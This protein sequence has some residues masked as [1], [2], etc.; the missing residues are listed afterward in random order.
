MYP[1][2]E[3]SVKVSKNVMLQCKKKEC[4]TQDNLNAKRKIEW[5]R[6]GVGVRWYSVRVSPS[7]L[8]LSL[9]KY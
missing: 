1:V 4:M 2:E 8:L 9:G 7:A 3:E 5:M 6:T